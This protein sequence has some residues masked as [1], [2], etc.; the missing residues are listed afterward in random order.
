MACMTSLQVRGKQ[1]T[2]KMGKVARP[3]LSRL[4]HVNEKI[5]YSACS[6]V[7]RNSVGWSNEKNIFYLKK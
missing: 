1:L 3:A 2:H 5:E 6:Y 7:K 4:G